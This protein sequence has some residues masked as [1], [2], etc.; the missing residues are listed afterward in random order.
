VV[1]I[2]GTIEDNLR[3]SGG[4]GPLGDQAPDNLRFVDLR[5]LP[6]P[7]LRLE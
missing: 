6:A 7:E 5:L 2:P 1:A 4:A 3:D